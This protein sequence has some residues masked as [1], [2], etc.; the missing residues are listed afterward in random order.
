MTQILIIADD[1]SGAADCASA[2]HKAGLSAMVHLD[3]TAA[4]GDSEPSEQVRAVD[5][6]S[7]RLAPAEAAA[8]Q[9][10]ALDNHGAGA[11]WLYKKIDST[12][13]GPIGAE[14]ATLIARAGLAIVAPAFAQAGRTTVRGHQYVD[15]VPLEQTAVWRT[16][17]LTG[18]AYIP[19]LLRSHGIAVAAVG[20]DDVRRGAEPLRARIEQLAAEGTQ[21][22]VCD[23]ETDADLAHIAQASTPIVLP[24]FWVGSAGLAQH[25]VPQ[26]DSVALGGRRATSLWPQGA[27]R[28]RNGGAILT[29][30]GSLSARSREQAAQLRDMGRVEALEV[31]ANVLR[32]GAGTAAWQSLGQALENSLSAGRDVMITVACVEPVNIHEGL[33]LCTALATL[34]APSGRHLG[35]LIATGG[36]TAR[37]IL[38]ALGATG[39]SLQGEIESGVPLSIAYGIPSILVVTKAGAFGS[40]TTLLRSLQTLRALRS[41]PASVTGRPAP[42]VSQPPSLSS[43]KASLTP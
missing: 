1:L 10:E 12:L 7:R 17:G 37:A 42:G 8:R 27:G 24:R 43:S 19:D 15:G 29:V 41:D 28:L 4:A 32:Q 16:E 36:E 31:P 9:L 25:L 3:A 13:R 6:D 33:Q 18:T 11:Q 39:L 38:N 20:L 35:G 2:F 21:A 23:A 40:P 22:V 14:L 34:I 26:P 5:A 30:V